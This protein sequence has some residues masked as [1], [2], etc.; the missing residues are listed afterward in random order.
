LK[1]GWIVKT[2][3]RNN[4]NLWNLRPMR[5]NPAAALATET[6]PNYASTAADDFM[7]SWRC[8]QKSKFVG[9]KK[10]CWRESAAAGALAI[11]AM[12]NQLDNRFFR[13]FVANIFTGAPAGQ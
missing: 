8:L 3:D 4:L 1:T 9:R 10:H 12:A 11:A 5:G 7:K 2:A 6:S 13:A